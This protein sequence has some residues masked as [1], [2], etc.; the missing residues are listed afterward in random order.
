MMNDTQRQILHL[1]WIALIVARPTSNLFMHLDIMFIVS[2]RGACL[3]DS[4]LEEF[5]PVIMCVLADC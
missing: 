2:D 1:P 3:V 5:A 4:I